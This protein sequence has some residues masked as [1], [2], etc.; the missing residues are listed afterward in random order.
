MHD[1]FLSGPV[2]GAASKRT[3]VPSASQLPHGHG[4]W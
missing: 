3:M 4:G 1:E 2:G